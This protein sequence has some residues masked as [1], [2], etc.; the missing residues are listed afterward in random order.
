MN[1]PIC[2]SKPYPSLLDFILNLIVYFTKYSTSRKYEI[3]C[4]SSR[5]CIQLYNVFKEAVSIIHSIKR[6]FIYKN[7][8]D[9]CIRMV[10][11]A[12]NRD[13]NP[14]YATLKITLSKINQQALDL[15]FIR[16]N[17]LRKYL[18]STT[19]SSSDNS[20]KAIIVYGKRTLIIT[21]CSLIKYLPGQYYSCQNKEYIIFKKPVVRLEKA[22]EI[23]YTYDSKYFREI[24]EALK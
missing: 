6:Y 23:T 12:K 19:L 22:L 16:T 3:L 13:N 24:I 2:I 18:M 5:D 15:I 20:N 17:K 4:P 9:L 10:E 7:I 1:K 8:N 14:Y 21:L 11:D